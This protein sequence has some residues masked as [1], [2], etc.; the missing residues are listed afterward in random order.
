MNGPRGAWW[1]LFGSVLV[2]GACI[3]SH[4]SL[5]GEEEPDDGASGTSST[6]GGSGASNGGSSGSS[7][8]SGGTVATGG[9]A[10]SSGAAGSGGVCTPGSTRQAGCNECVCQDDGSWLCTRSAC[11]QCVEGETRFPDGCNECV[12]TNGAWGC[13]Q[14]ACRDRCEPGDVI[15][16]LDG[17]NTCTCDRTGAYRCTERDC[18]ACP[19]PVEPAECTVPY[20]YIRTPGTERCCFY[21]EACTA[22][23]LA[24]DLAY[25]TFAD[26]MAGPSDYG[27]RGD[28]DGDPF[29]GYETDLKT[30]KENCG[31]CGLVC[32]EIEGEPGTVSCQNGDCVLTP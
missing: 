25:A 22:P 5:V 27:R 7:G 30:S 24:D 8:A 12:C 9:T 1:T 17:C 26:C 4:D 16:S 29:T 13:T 21:A 15:P 32:A 28:C 11:P 23:V 10:G 14:M 20:Y 2:L 31:S 19:A 18:G 6:G 3:D